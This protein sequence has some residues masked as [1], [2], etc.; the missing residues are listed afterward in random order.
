MNGGSTFI[1]QAGG[2][3]V[4]VAQNVANFSYDANTGTV[5][6][7]AL[8][9]DGSGTLNGSSAYT[10]LTY[11]NGPAPGPQSNWNIVN[12]SSITWAGSGDTV[13]WDN[14]LNWSGANAS[15][16]AVSAVQLSG[17][18]ALQVSGVS[19]RPTGRRRAPASSFRARRARRSRVPQAPRASAA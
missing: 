6:L 13:H 4:G 12:G 17:S 2:G 7:A 9:L 19:V 10:F 14:V 16:G 1:L 15:G 5:N 8:A 18:Y 3:T 11:L